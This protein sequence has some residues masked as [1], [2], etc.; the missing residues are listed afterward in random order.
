MYIFKIKNCRRWHL[1]LSVAFAV[2]EIDGVGEDV[3]NWDI[4]AAAR[5]AATTEFVPL[6]E[7]PVIEALDE[8][9]EFV[10]IV[11][12]LGAFWF[13]S[14][15]LRLGGKTGVAFVEASEFEEPGKR[16]PLLSC[17]KLGIS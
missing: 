3:T 8:G 14:V 2:V 1:L 16:D 4:M 6:V 13:A 15:F 9:V 17:G 11:N 7:E 5:S 10:S 12:G